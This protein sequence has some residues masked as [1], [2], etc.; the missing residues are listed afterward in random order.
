M[1]GD[2][3]LKAL[4]DIAIK[5]DKAML[6]AS[7]KVGM[8]ATRVMKK[9]IQGRHKLNTKR[10]NP[11]PP[12]KSP[13]N[14]TGDLRRSIRSDVKKGFIG[15]TVIVGAYQVYAR[16]LEYGGKNWKSGAKYPFVEPTAKIMLTNNRAQNIYK[17]AMRDALSK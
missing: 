9:Q 16:Q 15:Y 10:P 2:K 17:N 1:N 3:A 4:Q 6:K 11:A 12:D 5:A 8:D 7:K 13:M 14:V